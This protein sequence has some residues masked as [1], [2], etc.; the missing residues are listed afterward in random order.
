MCGIAGFWQARGAPH[1]DLAADAR[2]MADTLA[3]RGPD[4]EGVWV[5]PGACIALAHRRLSIVDLSPEG[6]QPM[7]SASRRYVI[8]FNGEIYNYRDLRAELETQRAAPRWRGHSDTEVL[9]AAVEH[10]GL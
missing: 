1:A 8:V 9:L 2:A 3:H 10:W 4:D 5:D 7:H 6:H